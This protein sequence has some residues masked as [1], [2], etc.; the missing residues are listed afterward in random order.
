ML[1]VLAHIGFTTTVLESAA[2]SIGA[3]MLIGGFVFG[4]AGLVLKWPREELEKRAL[5]DGYS[6]GLV[7]V[8][9]LIFDLVMRYV[10]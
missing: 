5:G 2:T 9:L 10:V 7:A 4:A 8:A 3:G 1:Q 6:G